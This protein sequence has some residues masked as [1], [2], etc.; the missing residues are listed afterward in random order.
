MGIYEE[1]KF[2]GIYFLVTNLFTNWVI[3][4]FCSNFIEISRYFV[5]LGGKAGKYPKDIY[6]SLDK[7]KKAQLTLSNPSD[8]KACKNCSNWT[9]FVLFHRIPFPRI[10]KFRPKP[11]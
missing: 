8:V 3:T 7:N 4:H 9:C 11:I 6:L 10:S 5:D 2:S 1:G